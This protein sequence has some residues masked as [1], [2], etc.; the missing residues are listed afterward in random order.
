MESS[1][2]RLLLL[3]MVVAAVVMV[4]TGT[5]AAQDDADS[6]GETCVP[7]RSAATGTTRGEVQH[8]GNP[9]Y[10]DVFV[11]ESYDPTAQTPLVLSLHGLTSNPDQQAFITEWNEVAAAN[12]FIVAYP[13]ATGLITRWNASDIPGSPDVDDVGFIDTLVDELA[14][15]YCIDRDRV[16]VNGFSNGGGMTERLACE[17]SDEIAAIGTV[18]GA[19]APLDTACALERPIPL[20]AFHGTGDPIVSYEGGESGNISLP[21]IPEWVESWADRLGCDAA[22]ESLT[23]GDDVEGRRY[24]GCDGDAQMVFYTVDN[25]GHVWPGGRPIAGGLLGYLTDTI[26]ASEAMWDFFQQYELP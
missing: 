6:D 10:Y 4:A 13:R 24:T 9:R 15:M 16:Y 11:P 19:Y 18:A 17:M 7:L 20:M 12:G 5:A 2:K 1:M 23:P 22:Y 25:G 26:D 8:D 3:V 14:N 21:P